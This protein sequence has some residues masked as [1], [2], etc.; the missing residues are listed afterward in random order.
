MRDEQFREVNCVG[1]DPITD[2][3]GYRISYN[4]TGGSRVVV[5]QVGPNVTRYSLGRLP[6]GN[7]YAFVRSFNSHG[8]ESA[9]SNVRNWVVR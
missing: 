2:L 5:I 1:G 4:T 7:W 8:R 3:A 9:P 6:P